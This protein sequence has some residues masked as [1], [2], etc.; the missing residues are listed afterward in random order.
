M[1]IRLTGSLAVTGS[2]TTDEVTSPILTGTASLA[3]TSSYIAASNV[4]GTVTSATT[5][6]TASYVA[7]SNIDGTITNATSASLAT[8]SSYIEGANV[9][10]AVASA[11]SAT[12]ATTATT[13]TTASYIAGANVDGTVANSTSASRAVTTLLADTAQT[14]SYVIA[15]N[16]HGEYDKHII[17]VDNETYDLGSSSNRWRDLYLS[18][19]TI[20]LGDQEITATDY[21]AI[22]SSSGTATIAATSSYIAG[23]NIDGAVATATTASYA[24]T[25]SYALNGGGGGAAFPHTGS[26]IISGSLELTGSLNANGNIQFK[27]NSSG[28]SGSGVWSTGNNLINNARRV[29]GTG[30]QNAALAFGLAANGVTTNCTEEYDGTSWTAGGA[31]ATAR[32]NLAGAGTQNAALAFGGDILTSPSSDCCGGCCGDSGGRIVGC[33]EEYNGSSWAAG[34]TLIQIAN[35]QGG[36]GTQDA[37]LSIGGTS[38]SICNL[39]NNGLLSCTEEYDGSSW[40]AG[41]TLIT[42]R[43]FVE[44]AGTQNSGLAFGAIGFSESGCSTN[45]NEEYNGTSWSAGGAMNRTFSKGGFGAG[46]TQNDALAARG[47]NNAFPDTSTYTEEYD[48]TSWSSGGTQITLR[49]NSAMGAN[50]TGAGVLFGGLDNIPTDQGG[51]RQTEEYN[52]AFGSG[53]TN[54]NFSPITGQTMIIP[55]TTDP[56]IAGALWNNN[57][58]LSIS[59][60]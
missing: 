26:A 54:F 23:E 46:G 45:C 22:S 15:F 47:T 43:R 17:P 1:A 13:A 14:A 9:D 20:Y 42:A 48:G 59:A 21:A 32:Y 56:G 24:V 35:Q 30:I 60:G 39:P 52:K 37:A 25:A 40:T 3:S 29:D 50:S 10:G 4:D 49:Y 28:F 38:R 12:S 8:T 53:V 2:I 44:G 34:G 31:L 6:N 55:P 41:G 36:T 51:N 57:G 16:I 5:S 7:A 58:T 33:T 18:G 11:T 19:S 27:T